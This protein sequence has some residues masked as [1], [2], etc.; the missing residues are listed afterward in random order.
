M[1]EAA[2][3]LLA[4]GF[5]GMHLHQIIGTCY[6]ANHASIR[7]LEKVGMHFE[8]C[9]RENRWCKGNWRSTNVHAL[10]EREWQA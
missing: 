6:P 5:Q 2:G 1:S 9:L 8:G 7:V 4:F 10:L 3:T